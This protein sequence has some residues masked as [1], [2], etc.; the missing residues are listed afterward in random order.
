MSPGRQGI[1]FSDTQL[2]TISTHGITSGAELGPEIGIVE[3]RVYEQKRTA[4]IGGI[5][6]RLLES[7]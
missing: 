6:D 1:N 2:V 5:K 3:K 4:V 7:I